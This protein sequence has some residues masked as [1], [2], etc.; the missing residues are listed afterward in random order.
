MDCI[1]RTY[2]IFVYCKQNFLR[3]TSRNVFDTVNI[4]DAFPCKGGIWV[5]PFETFMYSYVLKEIQDTI[6]LY[7]E[8]KDIRYNALINSLEKLK[9]SLTKPSF[10]QGY[11][12]RLFNLWDDVLLNDLFTKSENEAKLLDKEKEEIENFKKEVSSYRETFLTEIA[13]NQK[14]DFLKN[15][16]LCEVEKI[17][18]ILDNFDKIRPEYILHNHWGNLSLNILTYCHDNKT[19]LEASGKFNACLFNF[20]KTYGTPIA[21]EKLIENAPN[22]F[23]LL[24]T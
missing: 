17:K 24:G 1:G 6:N 4:R 13:D 9:Q 5:S 15:M 23:K 22:M 10:G 19:L 16:F 14:Y 20:L 12:P 21:C 18:T 2:N 11:P 8:K 7:K 3:D